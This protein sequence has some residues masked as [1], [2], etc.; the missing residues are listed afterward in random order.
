MAALHCVLW[1]FIIFAGMKP[2]LSIIL[3]FFFVAACNHPVKVVEPAETP[4][5]ELAA[6]DSLM[7]HQPDSAFALLQEFAASPTANSLNVFNGHY[8]Q[9]LISELLYKND[10]EQS[11]RT[12]LLQAVAYFDSLAGTHDVSLQPDS[13]RDA[14]HV[15]AKNAPNKAVAFL[16]ARAHYINGV[17]YYENDSVVEACAEYLKAL[18][19]MEEHFGEKELVGHEARFMAY[20]YNRLGDMFSEQFM[21]EPAVECFKNSY[22]FSVISPNSLY[23]V[24]NAMYRIG[25]QFNMKGN[26]DSANYYYSQAIENLPDTANLF[27]RDIV[28]NQAILSYQMTH[29]A[30][31]PLKRLRQMV[32]LAADD[33][34]K[35]TR[36]FVIGGIYFE[37]GLY[38]SASIYL[39]SV[40][41]NN[42]EDVSQ[43]QA[44]HYLHVIF[45]SL[46]NTEKSD[47]FMR[48]LAQQKKSEGQNKA[49]VSSL[50]N[51]FINYISQKQEKTAEK[52]QE[53][54]IRNAIGIIVSIAVAVTLAIF[55]MAKLRS[56]E[57][58]K[59]LQEDANRMLGDKEKRHQQEIKE[60]E[61]KARKE[62]EERDMRY[63]ETIEAE[64][65]V[66]RM[67]RAAM[68]GKL[69][70]R[71]EEVRELKEQVRRQDDLDATPKYAE[72]FTEEPICRLIMERVNE[73]RFLSQ[74]DCTIY[75]DYAL[76][77]E[78]VIALRE[79]VNRHFGLFTVRLAK[80][81]PE[82]TKNDLDYCCL[83][84]L[85]LTDADIAALMQRAYNT[86]NERNS[87]LR[88][89]LGNE[90]AISITMQAIANKS[91]SI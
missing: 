56:K 84:L 86:V 49:L 76:T 34:E 25:K 79:A 53:K 33:D 37:E 29:Q 47:V 71:N 58:L 36:Y 77:K 83:Y 31:T 26:I 17:G 15:S 28:S 87:K 70:R 13:C 32:V 82:L 69:K 10:C 18:E 72:L 21:M 11:N 55:V 64:R 59:K 3:A 62:L 50:E 5:S 89:I 14:S 88:R 24:S 66:H 60:K 27:Y 51:M 85:G 61:A 65:Q 41:E 1:D 45:D 43:T 4:S 44:A 35:L 73:G 39:E 42:K 63:A 91:V 9:L 20:T 57:L 81:Y 23:S 8:C 16:D 78:Q 6:I 38:D 68:A 22:V 54:S 75:K 46:G 52:A 74:M 40:F 7:W 19:V 90:N 12:E 67:E 30:E 2:R 80:A 48:F